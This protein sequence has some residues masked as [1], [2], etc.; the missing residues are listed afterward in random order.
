MPTTTRAVPELRGDPIELARSLSPLLA[1]H[2][3]EIDRTSRVPESVMTAI[4]DTGLPWM[5]VPERAGGAGV[6][7]RTHIEAVAELGR[8]SAGG[9]W[10]VGL[11]M[12][13]T[14]A[15]ASLPEPAVARIFQTG[16]ELVCGVTMLIGTARPVEDGYVVN[17]RW[18][19]AS[20][21]QYANWGMGG[22]RILDDRGE[23]TGVG[24]AF[25]P[26]GDGGLSVD[27]TW[28]V[29]GMR[30]SAS[31]TIVAQ[32][33]FVPCE[34]VAHI[35]P[36]RVE[37]PPPGPPPFDLEP[38]DRWPTAVFLGL[39]LLA[40]LL[41][42]ADNLLGLI[43]ANVGKKPI[44]HWDYARQ[45]DSHVV[46]QQIGEAAM[47]IDTA[48][49]HILRTADALDITA[50][51]GPVSPSEQVRLQAA[52]G[53]AMRMIR[54]AADRLMD[55]GGASAFTL[56]N[57][58]QRAWRDIALGSRHAFVN[59]GQSLELYGRHL[60]GERLQS[61]LFRSVVGQD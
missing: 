23:V 27:H 16:R 35:N 58:L 11:L 54:Q 34:L 50:Q 51:A 22:L 25:M 20:G 59:T 40:P 37:S 52:E 31:D 53:F 61:G 39:A 10:Q 57:P 44:T 32:D 2:D 41:G 15:A 38:R 19:Y 33:L 17:G 42:A 48:W 12:N 60:A 8:G 3:C 18:P 21:S 7:M 14:A 4:M 43:L 29:A 26:I 30:G 13:T 47:E 6:N 1:E 24:L 36:Q 46:L 56:S 49:L 5:M 45:A 28:D 9:A 55:V